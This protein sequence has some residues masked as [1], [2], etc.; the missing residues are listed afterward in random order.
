M[1]IEE[2]K[3]KMQRLLNQGRNDENLNEKYRKALKD[4]NHYENQFKIKDYGHNK[5]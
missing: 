5:M 2:I 4:A 3:K 1:E